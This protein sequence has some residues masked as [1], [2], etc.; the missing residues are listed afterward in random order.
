MLHCISSNIIQYFLYKTLNV[1]NK[2]PAKKVEMHNP[3]IFTPQNSS[4]SENFK[5]AGLHV[6][7][8]LVYFL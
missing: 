8:E 3:K 7:C 5:I 2:L 1:I 4:W 6:N